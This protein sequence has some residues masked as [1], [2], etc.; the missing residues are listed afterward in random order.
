MHFKTILFPTDMSKRS[1]APL[2]YIMDLVRRHRSRVIVIHVVENLDELSHLNIPERPLE[3][4]NRERMTIARKKLKEFTIRNLGK[5]PG[6]SQEV[7]RGIPYRAIVETARKKKASIIVMGVHG[8][9][10]LE[11]FLIG[12]NVL[13]VVRT[14]PCPVLTVREK[15]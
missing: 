11:S 12:S 14:A 8:G 6:V 4:L 13:R 9:G 3:E 1:E 15:P 2:P 10:G 5:L 7:I